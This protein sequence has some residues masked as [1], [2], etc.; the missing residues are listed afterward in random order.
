[1]SNY[2]VFPAK[3]LH[4]CSD[5]ALRDWAER[6]GKL[7]TVFAGLSLGVMDYGD[8]K[9]LGRS[10]SKTVK[11]N[12]EAPLSDVANVTRMMVRINPI[13]SHAP[14]GLSPLH[15]IGGATSSIPDPTSQSSPAAR[16]PPPLAIGPHRAGRLGSFMH[17]PRTRRGGS[18]WVKQ[19]EQNI[20]E[21][22]GDN[23][24]LSVL[25][26]VSS[27]LHYSPIPPFNIH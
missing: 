15:D 22:L 1:M 12:Q 21:V 5:D 11:S 8:I 26:G 25:R 13:N 19:S 7:V 6:M 2:S 16:L 14:L 24:C 4:R 9:L 3:H 18:G 17:S 27:L 10:S 20:D 23:T